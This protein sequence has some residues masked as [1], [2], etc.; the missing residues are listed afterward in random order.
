[1]SSPPVLLRLGRHQP[2]LAAAKEH[3]HTFHF[4][5]KKNQNTAHIV[6]TLL[7]CLIWLNNFIQITKGGNMKWTDESLKCQRPSAALGKGFRSFPGEIANCQEWGEGLRMGLLQVKGRLSW[8]RWD[9]LCAPTCPLPWAGP[10]LN[11]DTITQVQ[12]WAPSSCLV[13][14]RELEPPTA[15]P[16]PLLQGRS[17]TQMCP[18]RGAE[19]QEKKKLERRE[20]EPSRSS[21]PIY[22]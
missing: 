14:Q 20:R 3:T 12:C 16:T 4:I 11:H 15:G 5:K 6:L 13:P 10:L 2:A 9:C 7:I 21:L 1:M 17:Y 18:R 8:S 19:R 22:L